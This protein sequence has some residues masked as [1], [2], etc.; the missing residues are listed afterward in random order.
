MRFPIVDCKDDFT[1]S[2]NGFFKDPQDSTS[3]DLKEIPDD[4]TCACAC[5]DDIDCIG[6]V[7]SKHYDGQ[8]KL[9]HGLGTPVREHWASAYKKKKKG[10]TLLEI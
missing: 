5:S 3:L 10:D 9:H 7:Y 8:C 6:Y 2:H 1:F 4:N